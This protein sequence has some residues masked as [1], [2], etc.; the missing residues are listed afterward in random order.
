MAAFGILKA[1]KDV[2]A[3]MFIQDIVERGVARK[4]TQVEIDSYKRPVVCL[5]H[6]EIL[7]VDSEF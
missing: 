7:K 4:L 5:S 2:Y 3:E 1:Q 6:H